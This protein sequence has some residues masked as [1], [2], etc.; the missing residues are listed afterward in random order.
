MATIVQNR[1][2]PGEIRVA[3]V[4]DT[5]GTIRPIWFEQIEAPAEGRIFVTKVNMIWSYL[6]G[7]AKN[8]AFAVTAS[9]HN[10]TLI[11]DTED[12]TWSLSLVET[13]PLE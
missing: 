2:L 4:F 10:Y 13:V 5:G 9:D 7:S 3:T 11:F 12:L 1:D 8:I 6:V